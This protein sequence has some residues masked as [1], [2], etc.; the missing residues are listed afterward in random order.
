LSITRTTIKIL[1]ESSFF[2]GFRNK[3]IINRFDK[4]WLEDEEKVRKAETKNQANNL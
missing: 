2:F 1:R 4:G 3:R